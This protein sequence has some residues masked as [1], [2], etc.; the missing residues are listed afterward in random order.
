MNPG[1]PSRPAAGTSLPNGL[2]A[3]PAVPGD[4]AAAPLREFAIIER[5]QRLAPPAPGIPVGI[6]DDC[7]VLDAAGRAAAAAPVQLLATVDLIA[8]GT[9]FT[10]PPA[11]ARQI[12]HKALAVN[13]SDI[14]AMAGR[15]WAAFTAVALPRRLGAD[16]AAELLDGINAAAMDAGVVIAGGDTNIWD[17]PLV[18]SITLLGLTTGRGP[19]LRRGARPGDWLFVT[20]PL[21]GSLASGRHLQVRPRVELAQRLHTAVELHAMLDLSD[22]LSRDLPHL[23]TEQGLGAVVRAAAIPIHTDV[24]GD[25]PPRDRLRH[26]LD[27]GEDFELLFAVSPDDG[28]RLERLDHGSERLVRIGEVDGESTS[29]RLEFADGRSEPLQPRGYEHS[30]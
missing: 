21:G 8:E 26:A 3:V 15:P 1:P 11:T 6:G 29:C 30:F 7:A 25:L 2:A 9:H 22:G 18:V 4:L 12:G 13:L 17:G 5:L 19:V 28:R 10:I 24:P 16:W 20:G 27:D 14:A 23:T